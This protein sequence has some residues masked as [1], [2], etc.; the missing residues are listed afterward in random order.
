MAKYEELWGQENPT[1]NI[2]VQDIFINKSDIDILGAKKNTIKFK[3]NGVEY[4][5]FRADKLINEIDEYSDSIMITIVGRAGIN[6]WGGQFTPQIMIEDY[7]I[8]DGTM[9]F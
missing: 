8:E 1:P 2:L 7:E 5:Q 3:K 6:D 9:S 4:I